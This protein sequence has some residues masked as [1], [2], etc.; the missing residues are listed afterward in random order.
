MGAFFVQQ[1]GEALTLLGGKVDGAARRL[2]TAL[3]HDQRQHAEAAQQQD[4]RAEPQQPGPA[5]RLPASASLAGLVEQALVQRRQLLAP[6]GLVDHADELVPD[7]ALGVDDE[8]LRRAVHTQVQAEGAV[9]VTDADL[10]GVVELGQP[11]DRSRVLVLVVDPV[12]HH[13]LLGQLVQH[14]V[15]DL[16]RGAPGGPH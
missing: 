5:A 9:L 8:G 2:G 12:D 10:V 14:R 16:A 1:F 3:A 6:H 11:L 15:L 4:A 7:D 13:A